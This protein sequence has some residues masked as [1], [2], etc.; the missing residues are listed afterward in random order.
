MGVDGF[1]QSYTQ[2]I[3]ATTSRGCCKTLHSVGSKR[4]IWPEKVFANQYNTLKGSTAGWNCYDLIFSETQTQEQSFS[5]LLH[6]SLAGSFISWPHMVL[7][8][9]IFFFSYLGRVNKKKIAVAV[10]CRMTLT[11]GDSLW[12]IS[13]SQ[14]FHS[15][16]LLSAQL[17]WNL[18]GSDTKK[19][20]G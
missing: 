19:S 2:Q 8:A 18:A 1:H 16:F 6:P 15:T 7:R 13:D 9:A 14:C 20:T 10:L 4:I 12:P 17:D 3:N 11:G 5:T